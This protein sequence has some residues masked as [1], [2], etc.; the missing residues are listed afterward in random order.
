MEKPT[1]LIVG[2]GDGLSASLARLLNA[3]GYRLVL[4]ARNTEKIKQLAKE[5]GATTVS[6]DASKLDDVK[7][8]FASIAEA[9]QSG[10]L[11]PLGPSARSHCGT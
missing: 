6:C 7:A 9:T 3:E 2:V 4:A 8:L 11:Q 5:T 1:A 10:R